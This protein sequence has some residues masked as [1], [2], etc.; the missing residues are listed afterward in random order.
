MEKIATSLCS[1]ERLHNRHI[2]D[3]ALAC[4][5]TLRHRTG[6]MWWCGP[7]DAAKDVAV[8][9][10]GIA[11]TK[12]IERKILLWNEQYNVLVV[13]PIQEHYRYVFEGDDID[14]VVALYCALADWYLPADAQVRVTAG[15]GWGGKIAY[16]LACRLAAERGQLPAVVMGDSVISMKPELTAAAL[17]G[18]LD[19]W[20]TKNRFKLGDSFKERLAIVSQIESH[21]V[22]LPRYAGRVILLHSLKPLLCP[23]GNDEAWHRI[24]DNLTVIR[25]PFRY[26]E[27]GPDNEATMPMWR[28]VER[29]IRLWDRMLRGKEEME[30][31]WRDEIVAAFRP[32]TEKILSGIEVLEEADAAAGPWREAAS[33]TGLFHRLDAA[34]IDCKKL[35]VPVWPIEPRRFVWWI[36]LF[37][38]DYFFRPEESPAAAYAVQ[39][40]G[41]AVEIS[42]DGTSNTWVYLPSKKT[43]PT[44]YALEFD[45]TVHQPLKETLQLCFA[46]DSL[47]ERLRFVL[48]DNA[49]LGFE[50]VKSGL[51]PSR[52]EKDL[53]AF[54]RKPCS[55]PLGR[56]VRVRLEVDGDAFRLSFDDVCAMAVKCHGIVP[57]P[58]R[59]AIIAW[60][61]FGT[62]EMKV[63][64]EN[65]KVYERVPLSR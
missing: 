29:A 33:G 21:G 62:G 30:T 41:R 20:E 59:W 31:V 48:N 11:L 55:I 24:V 43:Y 25:L 35:F 26:D 63:K 16:L 13:E 28:T 9:V 27:I 5:E 40:D 54:C 14:E 61:G 36:G 58:A 19:D 50:V 23:P 47:A 44:T 51:F 39:D 12:D 32:R 34:S 57:H 7:Y 15:V 17:G 52:H 18:T 37:T 1:L 46:F 64:I 8:F 3:G 60:N 4:R 38:G 22:T 6:L 49:S 65:L 2:R 56:P 53:W 10:H 42:T 45:Y